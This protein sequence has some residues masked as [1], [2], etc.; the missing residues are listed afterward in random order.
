MKT[1]SD[2]LNLIEGM[3]QN[4]PTGSSMVLIAYRMLCEGRM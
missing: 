4:T 1:I 3:R 2:Y